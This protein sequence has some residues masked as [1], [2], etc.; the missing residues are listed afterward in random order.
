M[1]VLQHARPSNQGQ[2]FTPNTDLP[3]HLDL[4]QNRSMIP[5]TPVLQAVRRASQR[6]SSDVHEDMNQGI[7]S[8]ATIASVAPLVGFLGTIP[9]MIDSF[10]GGSYEKETRMFLTFRWLSDSLWPSAFGVFVGIVALLCHRYVSSN[11]LALDHDMDLGGRTLV[12]QLARYGALMSPSDSLEDRPFLNAQSLSALRQDQE[13]RRRLLIL[14]GIALLLVWCIQSAMY[15]FFDSIPFDSLLQPA[16]I[17]LWVVLAFS[18]FLVYPL[19]VRVLHRRRGTLVALGSA[20]ALCW[21]IG[22]AAY[23]FW[24]L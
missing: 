5:T 4:L 6:A 15:F 19:W 21:I 16:A 23:R 11:L 17:K 18:C 12:D 7:S 3:F 1:S 10:P 24:H 22:E 14:A 13:R 8:L 9:M 2:C 20:L